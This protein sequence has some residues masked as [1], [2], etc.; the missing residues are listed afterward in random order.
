VPEL[1]DGAIPIRPDWVCELLSP[2]RVDHD[3]KFKARVYL[4]E[5][6]PWY[7]LGYPEGGVIQVLRNTGTEW[8]VH[9][10]YSRTDTARIPP[11][12]E[13]ELTLSGLFLPVKRRGAPLVQGNRRTRR[14]G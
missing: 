7:W 12:E 3:V 1:P 14:P 13:L 11:F 8:A 2:E 9:G 4:E 6:V 10:S 5:G